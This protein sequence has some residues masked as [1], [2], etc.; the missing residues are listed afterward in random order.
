MQILYVTIDLLKSEPRMMN[1]VVGGDKLDY[2]GG[3]RA[4]AASL[5]ET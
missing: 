3:S 5:I 2:E 4:P 1:L